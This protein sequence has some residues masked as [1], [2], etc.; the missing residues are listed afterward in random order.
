MENFWYNGEIEV[1]HLIK[2]AISHYQFETIHPFLDGNGRVGRLLIT[3]Y[4]VSFG[5]LNKPSLYLSDFFEK[6]RISY[7]DALSRVRAANDLAHWIKFFLNAVIETA[8]KGKRTFKE[9]LAS[10]EI[11]Y[12]KIVTLNRRAQKGQELVHYLYRHPLITAGDIVI[13]L[14]VSVPTAN[15]L[16]NSF[17]EL[18]ILREITGLRRNRI[19]EFSEYIELF[20]RE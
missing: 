3:L 8:E 19:Y 16:I 12:G 13:N 9:I 20:R 4:L 15:D 14:D 10:K 2:V 1:P 7:Y 5:L 17:V 18:G 11:I 6:R